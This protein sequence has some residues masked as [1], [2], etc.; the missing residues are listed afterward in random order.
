MMQQGKVNAFLEWASSGVAHGPNKLYARFLR[1]RAVTLVDQDVGGHCRIDYR[2]VA[3]ENRPMAGNLFQRL[4]NPTVGNP[5]HSEVKSRG[6]LHAP[7][8]RRRAV[9]RA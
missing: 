7:L 4:T 6:P 8:F 2:P 5:C 1:L 9:H 3:W